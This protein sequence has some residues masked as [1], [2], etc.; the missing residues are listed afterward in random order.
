MSELPRLD[1][2]VWLSVHAGHDADGILYADS[3][4]RSFDHPHE[5]LDCLLLAAIGS[6]GG[7]MPRP[8][9]SQMGAFGVCNHHIPPVRK[10]R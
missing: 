10:M 6:L 3:R 1:N 8:T 5:K 9:D 7:E 4:D 2:L